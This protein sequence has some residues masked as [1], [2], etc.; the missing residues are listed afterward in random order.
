MFFMQFG[1]GVSILRILAPKSSGER[2]D[3]LCGSEHVMAV[4]P[5]PFIQAGQV[6]PASRGNA[7]AASSQRDML[8]AVGPGRLPAQV[9]IQ[10]MVSARSPGA[11]AEGG[12]LRLTHQCRRARSPPAHHRITCRSAVR[13]PA[14]RW[15]LRQCHGGLDG[16]GM[17]RRR[18]SLRPRLLRVRRPVAGR[19]RLLH[20]SRPGGE[21]GGCQ[22]RGA[23]LSSASDRR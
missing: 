8:P 16:T 1:C 11:L 21:S 3:R 19:R 15:L 4:T 10:P 20:G 12:C 13:L 6:I 2:S 5:P 14:V 18:C 22:Y 23:R 17:R 9:V 7:D